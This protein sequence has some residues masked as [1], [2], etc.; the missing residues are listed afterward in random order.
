MIIF[1]A[2]TP[3]QCGPENNNNDKAPEL[4]PHRLMLYV[5]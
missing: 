4:K 5:R 3:D 1:G 2:A